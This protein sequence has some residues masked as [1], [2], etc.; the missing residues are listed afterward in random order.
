ML[1]F[2]YYRIVAAGHAQVSHGVNDMTDS[3]ILQSA[4]DAQAIVVFY[5]IWFALFYLLPIINRRKSSI[6]AR[7]M[8]AAALTLPGPTVDSI[9]FVGLG[10]AFLPGGISAM[11]VSF[12]LI[13]I[14]LGILL[15]KDHQH[16]RSLKTLLTCL[17]IYIPGQ[18]LHFVVLGQAWFADLVALI[19]LPK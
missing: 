13:D 4:A 16:N 3:E 19:M 14:I 8:V 7:Y 9:M 1:R 2:S 12:L 6:H 10:V 5:I 11:W 18:F 15:Y 17:L